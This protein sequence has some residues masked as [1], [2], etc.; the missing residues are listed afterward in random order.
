MAGLAQMGIHPVWIDNRRVDSAAMFMAYQST[1]TEAS[2][3]YGRLR[4]DVHRMISTGGA[5][6]EWPPSVDANPCSD[7]DCFRC[8]VGQ[9][10]YVFRWY[11]PSWEA[12]YLQLRRGNECW[13]PNETAAVA[14]RRDAQFYSRQP[15]HQAQTRARM[16]QMQD[17][18]EAAG[19]DLGQYLR[20]LV[21]GNRPRD[22]AQQP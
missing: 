5:Q 18:L 19:G 2:P 8:S 7:P 12:R 22:D 9:G 20:N 1:V 4:V 6:V 15:A 16:Q 3:W 21:A 14:A 13:T 11:H 10:G 17:G